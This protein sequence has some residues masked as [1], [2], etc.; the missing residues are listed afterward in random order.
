M[1]ETIRTKLN[2]LPDSPGCYLM[3]EQGKI[4]YVGKAVNLKNRVRSYFHSQEHTPKVAA[5][6]PHVDDLD[7]VICATN[8]EALI[9]ECNLIKKHKPYYNILLKDDKHYPYIRID[10]RE[11]FPRLNITRRVENDGALYFGPYIGA[12]AVRQVFGL[13]RR[14]YPLR[15]CNLKLPLKTPVRPCINYEIGQCLGPCAHKCTQEEYHQVVDQVIS[16]LRG[17]YKPI[18][19]RVQLQMQSAAQQMQYEKAGELRDAIRDIMGLMEQQN[20]LQTRGGEQD[21]LAVSQDSLD[22]MV[23]VLFVR[24]GK[25]I[26]GDAYALPREGNEPEADVLEGFL[27]QFYEDRRPAREVIVSALRDDGTMEAWLRSKRDGAV[28]LVMPLRGSKREL[29]EMARKNAA[30]ALQQRNANAQFKLERTRGAAE[31]LARALDLEAMPR[32]IEGFDIS[33]TQGEQSVASMVV[34]IDGE[35]AKREYRHFRIKT[36]QGA[37]DFQSMNEVLFRRFMRAMAEDEKE[38]WP[39]PDLVLVDGGPEQLHFARSAMLEAGADIPMF[40]LAK[41]MEEIWLPDRDEPIML[42]RRSAALHLIQRIR[43]E[44]HRFAITH[45]RK[46]RAKHSLRSRLEEVQGIGPA[47]R[48]ALLAHFRTMR[49]VGEA[50]IE[51]LSCVKGMTEPAA[52]ALYS[53]LHATEQ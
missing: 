38:R 35:P 29:V 32:R 48:R 27:T 1:N 21:I 20:V 37:N 6:L 23:Q 36:V 41:R 39:I 2:M 11:T 12:N 53:A 10:K 33:N 42:D 52:R 3:K 4:I 5:M 14:I 31:E 25:M 40:G 47:R 22:A 8:L 44:S 43:D 51:E 34:F 30:D 16:F 26:G 45:H 13:L 9:L 7:I 15:T 49:A 24:S 19:A 50:S 46:L 28:D 17:Q 18:V